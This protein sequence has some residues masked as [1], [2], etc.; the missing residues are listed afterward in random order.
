MKAYLLGRATRSEYWI[1]VVCMTVVGV[2]ANFIFKS[3]TLLSG[4]TFIP[5]AVIASRRL[6]DFGWSPWWC[7]STV[8]IG[9]IV[10]FVSSLI[11][12][13]AMADTGHPLIGAAM[14]KVT[15]GLANW[16][17]IIFIGSCKSAPVGADRP[18][19]GVEAAAL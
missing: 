16:A 7:V 1:F 11:N 8:A 17:V 5:W 2:I 18:A 19:A 15:Y 14:V 10:G 3:P 4:L 13:A 12:A 9:F 6:R